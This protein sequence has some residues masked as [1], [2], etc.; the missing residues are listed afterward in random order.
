MGFTV[1]CRKE[2]Y[3]LVGH[4]K[5]QTVIIPQATKEKKKQGEIKERANKETLHQ[6]SKNT[7]TQ[8]PVKANTD[9]VDKYEN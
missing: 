3:L 1:A 2:F 4:P 9:E 8:N 7:D 5:S 6:P